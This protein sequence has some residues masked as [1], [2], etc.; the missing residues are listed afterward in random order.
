VL[1]RQPV[2]GRIRWPNAIAIASQ[3]ESPAQHWRLWQDLSILPGFRAF[4]RPS[5]QILG[6]YFAV[7][8]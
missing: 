2:F 5:A 6:S 7:Q 8:K 1:A 3:R 4:L